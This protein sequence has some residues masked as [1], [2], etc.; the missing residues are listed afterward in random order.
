M[1]AATKLDTK[2]ATIYPT[3]FCHHIRP[4]FHYC[5]SAGLNLFKTQIITASCN[6]PEDCSGLRLSINSNCD[7]DTNSQRWKETHSLLL[8]FMTKSRSKAP[9]FRKFFV[10][11]NRDN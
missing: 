4:D 11:V 5:E 7:L 9:H 10:Y 1:L 8:L 3:D 2:C 6:E